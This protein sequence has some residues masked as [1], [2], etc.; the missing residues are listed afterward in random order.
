MVD[1][2]RAVF[3]SPHLDDAVFSCG[4]LLARLAKTGPVLVLNLFTEFPR[5]IQNRGIV[6]GSERYKEEVAAA[7]LC[8]W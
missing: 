1:A 5:P 7:R 6:L 2:Y 4:G 3:L 8:A